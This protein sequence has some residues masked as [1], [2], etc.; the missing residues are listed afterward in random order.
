MPISGVIDMGVNSNEKGTMGIR[1][2][3]CLSDQSLLRCLSK[4]ENR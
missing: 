1:R 4:E 3:R 2:N